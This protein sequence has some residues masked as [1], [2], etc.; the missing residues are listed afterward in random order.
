MA[1]D[2]EGETV[3]LSTFEF[4]GA[5]HPQGFT[6]LQDFDC[7]IAPPEPWVCFTWAVGDVKV[8][9]RIRMYQEHCTITYEVR[10]TRRWGA[11]VHGQADAHSN[12]GL[13]LCGASRRAARSNWRMPNAQYT[14]LRHGQGGRMSGGH[15]RAAEDAVLGGPGLVVQRHHASQGGGA[16]DGLRRG[17]VYA[18]LVQPQGEGPLVMQITAV[19]T[20]SD[21]V[22]GVRRAWKRLAGAADRVVADQRAA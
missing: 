16:S 6:R 7:E 9:K 20:A 1:G 2:G 21:V 5:I 18:R 8:I 11:A 13:P 10:P 12:A 3:D 15:R 4:N 22:D 19:P 17:P 14:S